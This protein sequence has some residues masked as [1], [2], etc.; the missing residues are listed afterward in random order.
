MLSSVAGIVDPGFLHDSYPPI[1]GFVPNTHRKTIRS[2]SSSA[3]P[4]CNPLT[5]IPSYQNKVYCWE[6]FR[7]SGILSLIPASLSLRLSPLI[8]GENPPPGLRGKTCGH[9]HFLYAI[10]DF[11]LCTYTTGFRR[12]LVFPCILI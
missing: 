1:R 6:G 5:V 10:L 4:I 3:N 2:A 12:C 11:I 8:F 7:Q 9:L